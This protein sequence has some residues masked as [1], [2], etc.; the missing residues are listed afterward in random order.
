MRILRVICNI[1]LFFAVLMSISLVQIGV[2]DLTA[3]QS[4]DVNAIHLLSPDD[5]SVAYFDTYAFWAEDIGENFKQPAKYRVRNWVNANWWKK[6]MAWLDVGIDAVVAAIK[7]V[8]VP[9]AQVNAIKNYHGYTI[10]DFD[11]YFLKY[12]YTS[13]TEYNNALYECYVIFEKGYGMA[14]TAGENPIPISE[15]EYSGSYIGDGGEIDYARWLQKN[16]QLYN[17]IWKL[18]K[19]NSKT[20][21]KYFSKFIEEQD[22]VRHIKVAAVVLYYQQ[23]VSIILAF[24]F[25]IKYPITLGQIRIEGK[26]RRRDE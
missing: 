18:Q 12:V 16:K 6:G 20:Y 11:D 21:D 2:Y 26:K 15:Y 4:D 5:E 19:Y 7:P 25:V 23:Y 9:I 8:V 13:E 17:N 14:M 1:L 24:I 22:G 10:N 3:A